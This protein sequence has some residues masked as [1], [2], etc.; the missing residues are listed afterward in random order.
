M[1]VVGAL[2]DEL[3][4]F[5]A[6]HPVAVTASAPEG[7]SRRTDASAVSESNGCMCVFGGRHGRQIRP[8]SR[9]A[10]CGLAPCAVRCPWVSSL[11]RSR[12]PTG[13]PKWNTGTERPPRVR[14]CVRCS[15]FRGEVRAC[16]RAC[17]RVVGARACHCSTVVGPPLYRHPLS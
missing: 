9:N 3:W 8:C 6:G 4:S 17:V 15:A 14:A 16:V 12:P 1:L 13:F 5:G 7:A 11:L 10:S 2:S